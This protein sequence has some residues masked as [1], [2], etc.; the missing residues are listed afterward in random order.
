[1]ELAKIEQLLETY[2]EGN[3]TLAEE[4][5]LEAYFTKGEIAP[6]L[7]TYQPLFAGFEA[8]RNEVSRQELQLPTLSASKNRAWWYG[9]AASVVI[10]IGIAGYTFSQPSLTA[11]EQE[12]IAAFNESKAAMKLL[13]QNFN[14]GTQDLALINQFTVSKNKILK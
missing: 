14:K 3:T 12:A 1:M 11:E 4:A 5:V 7:Q 13:A 2:F 6:H 8:A 10:A 9:L